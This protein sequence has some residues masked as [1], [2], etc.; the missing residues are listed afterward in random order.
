MTDQ[1]TTE[2]PEST[3]AD[4]S[5]A[6]TEK[7]AR[8]PRSAGAGFIAWIALLLAVVAFASAGFNYMKGRSA[9][10][11]AAAS[12]ADRDASL[13]N[14][15]SS[16][17]T[18]QESVQALEQRLA[19][20]TAGDAETKAAVESIDR[21]FTDRLRRLES[22]PGRMATVEASMATLQGISTGARE[23]WLLAEAEYYMQI[24]NAQLQ[25]ANNPELAMLALRHA[26]ER[27]VQIGDPRLTR[28][29]QA[30]SD[31]LRALEVMETPDTT[32]IT[33]AL[34]SLAAAVDSLPLAREAI[35]MTDEQDD[36]VDEELTGMD[37]AWASVK[38]ALDSVVTVR[39][40]EE[41]ERP[42]TSP[43]A[44]YFLR[45]NLALQLQAARL[46]LLRGEDE[47]YRQSLDDADRW[48]ADYY[49]TA[50]TAVVNARQTIADIRSSVFNV[51]QPDIS[52]SLLMLRQYNTLAEAANG[53]ASPPEPGPEPQ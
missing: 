36:L 2:I 22:L 23:A 42:L 13:R 26:D 8:A 7:P 16:V 51:A 33:L 49:S 25:L 5:P 40:A 15:A 17:G 12:T 21:Q 3:A 41:V 31:E 30:L 48:L 4:E 10:S 29:R 32:G 52:R 14:L 28:I 27:V 47:I 9:E 1:D 45:A 37:R 38:N 24:A 35:A 46:A 34:S 53:T 18:M 44:Q 39:D 19:A 43:G 50:S 6:D 20:L 11:S